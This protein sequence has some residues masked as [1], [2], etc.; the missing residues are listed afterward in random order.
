VDSIHMKETNKHDDFNRVSHPQADSERRTGS[1]H[2]STVHCSPII[3]VCLSN[4]GKGPIACLLI[5]ISSGIH[6]FQVTKY[7]RL[8]QAGWVTLKG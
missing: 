8:A 6:S 5:R 3:S 7:K 2:L 4:I 1:T